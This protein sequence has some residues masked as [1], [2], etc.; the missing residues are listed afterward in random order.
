MTQY[1]V[2]RGDSLS[3]IARR[4]HVPRWQ[5]IYNH[6][7]NADFKRRRPNPNLIYPGDVDFVPNGGVTPPGPAPVPRRL[8]YTVPGMIDVIAQP[9][10]LVCWATVYTMMRS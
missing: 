10:S 5:T 3:L 6:P 7:L 4:F 9:T 8:D 1:T 2:Q